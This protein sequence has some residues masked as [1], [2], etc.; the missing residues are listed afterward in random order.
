MD[1][2][3]SDN[4]PGRENIYSLIRYVVEDN[5]RLWRFLAVLGALGALAAVAGLRV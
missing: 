3:R 4:G 2:Q 1:F 5:G